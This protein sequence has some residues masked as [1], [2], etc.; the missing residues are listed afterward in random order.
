MKGSAPAAMVGAKLAEPDAMGIVAGGIGSPK[1]E[2]LG[3]I[4][5]TELAARVAA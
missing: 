3:V 1:L 2:A 5:I 4:G